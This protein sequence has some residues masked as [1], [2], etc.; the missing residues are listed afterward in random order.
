[1][2]AGLGGRVSI[3]ACNPALVGREAACSLAALAEV[4]PPADIL[5]CNVGGSLRVEVTPCWGDAGRRSGAC[6]CGCRPARNWLLSS[7]KGLVC[8]APH[9]DVLLEYVPAERMQLVTGHSLPEEFVV[10]E[11]SPQVRQTLLAGCGQAA[12]AT[13]YAVK[14][15]QMMF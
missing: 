10:L 2:W 11:S 5:T 9:Q 14:S 8:D 6:C 7:T 4:E 15:W 12:A 13:E 1:M 3:I